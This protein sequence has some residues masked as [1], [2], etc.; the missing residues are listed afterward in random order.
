LVPW[1]DINVMASA[2]D[3]VYQD[4]ERSRQMGN[5][6]RE[7]VRRKFMKEGYLDCWESLIADAILRFK[8][9]RSS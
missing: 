1:K 6:G 9:Q 4:V 7:T 3:N 5:F 2:I 8:T